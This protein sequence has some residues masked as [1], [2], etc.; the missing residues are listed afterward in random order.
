MQC[1]E[2]GGALTMISAHEYENGFTEQHQCVDC[3]RRG[4]VTVRGLDTSHDGVCV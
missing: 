4:R 1:N 2:C 3:G